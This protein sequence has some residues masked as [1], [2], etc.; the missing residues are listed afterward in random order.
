MRTALASLNDKHSALVSY[1]KLVK[2]EYGL[3][4]DTPDE[5]ICNL[6]REI[7]KE[8]TVTVEVTGEEPS[9]R[10]T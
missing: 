10:I 7:A 9:V 6:A 1:A 4:G 5:I 8:R 3:E 2:N